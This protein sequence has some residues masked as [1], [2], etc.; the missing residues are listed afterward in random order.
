MVMC[1]YEAWFSKSNNPSATAAENIEALFKKQRKDE[2][3]LYN[4]H[5]NISLNQC[6]GDNTRPVS[7]WLNVSDWREWD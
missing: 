4:R 7:D 1:C 3:T 2:N 6:V 5:R